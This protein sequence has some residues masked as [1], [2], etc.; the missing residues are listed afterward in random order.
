MTSEDDTCIWNIVVRRHVHVFCATF[1]QRF[2]LSTL[3]A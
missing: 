2:G 3:W 1:P